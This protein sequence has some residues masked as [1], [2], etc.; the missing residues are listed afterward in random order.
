MSTESPRQASPQSV[1][2]AQFL[3]PHRMHT[4]HTPS[5]IL[6][7]PPALNGQ[8]CKQMVVEHF[9]LFQL[10]SSFNFGCCP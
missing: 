8:R 4:A 1:H 2:G 5:D 3:L 6:L 7:R 10:L 9:G